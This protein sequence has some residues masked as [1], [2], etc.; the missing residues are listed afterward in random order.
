MLA[1]ITKLKLRQDKLEGVLNHMKAT[2]EDISKEIQNKDAKF[3]MA[4]EVKIDDAIAKWEMALEG[5]LKDR[6]AKLEIDIEEKFLKLVDNKLQGR[7]EDKVDDCMRKSMDS[8]HSEVTHS[9]DDKVKFLPSDVNECIQIER[10]KNNIVIHGVL[11]SDRE[12]KDIVYDI[13]GKGL[14][15]DPTRYVDEVS[16]IGQRKEKVRPIRLKVKS[17]E[18]K[19][20]LLR[21]AKMLKDTGY[22]K[23]FL[24]PDLTIKQQELDKQLRDELKRLRVSGETNVR[25]KSGKIIKIDEGGQF[26][27]MY[28][29]GRF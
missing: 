7:V 10:R 5:K 17:F 14:N 15:V 21:R 26:K 18:G 1:Q 8:F 22:E 20:E 2:V 3:E 28:Q 27:I 6:S 13:L 24:Q 23:V 9:M 19:N 11:E 12:D 16:R 25:I 4:I 29:K